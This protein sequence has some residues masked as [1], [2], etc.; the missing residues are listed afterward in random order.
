MH[1]VNAARGGIVDEEALA[2]GARRRPGRRRRRRRVRQGAVHRLPALRASSRS[3]PPRTSGRRTDEA[4]EKAGIAVARSVRLA[5]AGELVPDAVNVQGGVI[6][7]DVRPG[8]PAGREARPHLHRAGRRSCRSGS[9][10]RSAAR[11]PPTTSRCSSSPPS[12]ASS[13]TSSRSTVSYVNAPLLAKERGVEVALLTERGEP[14]LPQPAHRPR[15]AGRRRRGV[16][17]RHARRRQAS[18]EDRRGRRLR[19]RPQPDRRTWRSSATRTGRA[20]SA[21][22]GGI[23]GDAGVN[24]AGM[25]V[26]RDTRG[27]HALMVDSRSTPPCRTRCSAEIAAAIGAQRAR[28]VD[29]DS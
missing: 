28:H 14:R 17:L 7:E 23:L 26:S 18:R 1:I 2:V 19:R 27:G 10:S 6:A 11:S 13:P 20:W 16:G 12:R 8:H 4:Q 21:R 3:S 5:L 22:S 15:H 9:T 24:I 25:Q 29:L